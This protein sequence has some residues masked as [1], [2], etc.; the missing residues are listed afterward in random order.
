MDQVQTS[1]MV[2]TTTHR[3][4]GRVVIA[5]QRLQELLNNRMNTYVNLYDAELLPVRNYKDMPSHY[6]DLTIPKNSINLVLL[7]QQHHEAPTQRLYRYAAK[8]AYPTFLTVP[9]YEVQ[10]YLH[11]TTLQK[12]EVFLADTSTSFVPVTWA[13]VTCTAAVEQTWQTAVVFV[14]RCAVELFYLQGQL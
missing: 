1:I 13:Q 6:S 3:A 2:V 11:F 10:G 9:N 7:Q 8:S 12:P 4:A 14:R 5:G